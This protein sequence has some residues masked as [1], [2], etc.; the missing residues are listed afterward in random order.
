MSKS[1]SAAKRDAARD[2]ARRK[3]ERKKEKMQ[4]AEILKRI[5]AKARDIDELLD[6]VTD[7]L[8]AEYPPF[9]AIAYLVN[10]KNFTKQQI[11]MDVY[12][13]SCTYTLRNGDTDVSIWVDYS[14]RFEKFVMYISK[15]AK[16]GSHARSTA[17]V[18]TN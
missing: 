11:S 4:A 14:D 15:D 6:G 9:L 7:C 2:R 17:L 3:G 5:A 16:T 18:T 1:K 13:T 12:A 10:K 8:W